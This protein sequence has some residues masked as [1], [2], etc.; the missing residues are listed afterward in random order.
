MAYAFNERGEWFGGEWGS[1]L[2][3]AHAM[4]GTFDVEVPETIQDNFDFP[5]FELVT[6][7][8]ASRCAFW[9]NAG[10]LPIFS[11]GCNRIRLE[12]LWDGCNRSRGYL[13]GPAQ[14]LIRRVP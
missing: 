13:N 2:C 3:A 5:T 10:F 14:E 6:H 8:D 4:Y 9:R 11:E 7:I 12:T 1:D